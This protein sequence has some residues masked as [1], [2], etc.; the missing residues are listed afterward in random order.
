MIGCELCCTVWHIACIGMTQRKLMKLVKT[1]GDEEYGN[2]NDNNNN[3]ND[4]VPI[5]SSDEVLEAVHTNIGIEIKKNI[6]ESNDIAVNTGQRNDNA[7]DNH[8]VSVS[9]CLL[10]NG[11][12]D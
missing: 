1:I 12:S 3:V 11:N 2:M 8:S 5:H 4:D 9:Q 10:N 7:N 6:D